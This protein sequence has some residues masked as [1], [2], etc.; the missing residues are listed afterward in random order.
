LGS[1][2]W[3]IGYN[4]QAYLTVSKYLDNRENRSYMLVPV[5]ASREPRYPNTY[6][7]YNMFPPFLLSVW[8]SPF[9]SNLIGRVIF[10]AAHPDWE[11]NKR[12]KEEERRT[13]EGKRTGGNSRGKGSQVLHSRGILALWELLFAFSLLL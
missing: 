1:S 2:H 5:V 13:K 3:N 11:M 10:H 6:M 9:E 12:K 7:T 4:T 8:Y